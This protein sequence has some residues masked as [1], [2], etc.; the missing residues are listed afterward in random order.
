MT[1]QL[2]ICWYCQGE[3]GKTT[4]NEFW[5]FIVAR[6]VTLPDSHRHIHVYISC[7]WL[8][9]PHHQQSTNILQILWF[10]AFFGCHLFVFIHNC[11]DHLN[12]RIIIV[13]VTSLSSQITN[14]IASSRWHQAGSSP[15]YLCKSSLALRQIAQIMLIYCQ[16]ERSGHLG[17][18]LHPL[19]TWQNQSSSGS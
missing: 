9:F 2:N 4:W 10:A 1:S 19:D 16:V 15:I 14:A 18:L 7:V 8:P 6:S 17:S 13:L 5:L 3:R 11:L 12:S